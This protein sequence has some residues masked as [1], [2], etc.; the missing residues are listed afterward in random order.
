[1]AE[2]I[3]LSIIQGITEFIPVSSSAHLIL[4]S[5]YFDY[6]NSNLVIDVSLH[7]GSLL[8]IIFY[9][10][11]D[12]QNFLKNKIL[13]T[14]IIIATIPVAIFGFILAKLNYMDFLRSYEVIGWTTIIFGILLLV[15]D[16]R[17]TKKKMYKNLNYKNIIII[18][19]FQ[20]LAL[21]PGVSRS[22]ITITA[23]RF[24]DF[25]RVD[26]AKISFLTAIPVLFLASAYNFQEIIIENSFQISYLNFF[27]VIMSF[28]FS[29][30]TIKFLLNFL[31]KFNL[32]I[33]VLYRFVLG[34]IILIYVYN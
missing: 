3:L 27:G 30:I 6:S 1:M 29:Y 4:F 32:L 2:I 15:S 7:L 22:G 20:M 26:S 9:F 24:L 34:V 28:F 12:F 10:K 19:I 16:T 5:N 21:I 23:S 13:F 11:K 31:K 17:K 25:N 14:K 8:A 18:G 33:F